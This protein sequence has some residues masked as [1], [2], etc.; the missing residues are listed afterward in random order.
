MFDVAARCGSFKQAA[1]QLGVTQS[2]VTRQIQALEEQLD[3]RLFQR[4]NRVHSLTPVALELAPQIEQIFDQL[5]RAIER[6]RSVSDNTT[7]QLTVAISSERFRF[8]LADKL[9]DFHSLYPHIQ[10]NF[11]RCADY[12]SGEHVADMVSAVQHQSW[13]IAIGYGSINDKHLQSQRLS[14]TQLVPVSSLSTNETP[15][16]QNWI[17]NP[18]NPEHLKL[19]EHYQSK[20]KNQRI[21]HCDDFYM[22]LDLAQ[23]EKAVTLVDSS[24]LTTQFSHLTPF[25][26][27]A[28]ATKSPLSVFYKKRKRQPV[29][30]VA[31][32]KWLQLINQ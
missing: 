3:M 18:D 16:Q 19:T 12:F 6:T 10:L 20:L 9:E 28:Q 2:A 14:K 4:D 27:Y 24:L 17:I 23:T 26:E 22:S 13:D 30:L 32:I 15:F 29:A 1:Q 11:A 7:T 5:E 25:R 31:F 8:W 21:I